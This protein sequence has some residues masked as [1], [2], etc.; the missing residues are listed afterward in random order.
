VIVIDQ[1]LDLSKPGRHTIDVEFHG[2]VEIEGGA[3]A[4][5]KREAGLTIEVKPRDRARLQKRGAEWLQDIS[6]L[7]PGNPATTAAT[8]LVCMRDPV[9]VPYL[10]LAASRTRAP[11]YIDAL[12]A[13]NHP[14]AVEALVRL[15]R[16]ADPDVRAMAERGL[17]GK[18]ADFSLP[19]CASWG[20]R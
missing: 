8:A 12:R 7:P 20:A 4:A 2:A 18:Q 3:P 6:T 5:L 13:L 14:D 19:P 15:S 10:E 11:R 16:G 17:A 9:A 1:W